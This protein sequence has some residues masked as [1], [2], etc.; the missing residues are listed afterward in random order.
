ME[1][2]NNQALNALENI[3]LPNSKAELIELA[4]FLFTR[5]Y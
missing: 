4:N 2:H 3:E 1:F 5:A